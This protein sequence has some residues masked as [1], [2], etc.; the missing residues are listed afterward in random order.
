MAIGCPESNAN[1]A[2][3]ICQYDFKYVYRKMHIDFCGESPSYDEI[4]SFMTLTD[5]QKVEQLDVELDKCL[6]S[7][8]WMGK[9]GQVWQLAHRK[10]RPVGSLKYGEDAYTPYQFSDYYDDYSLFVY[11]QIDNHDARDILLATYF[12]ERSSDPTTYK[13][14]EKGALIGL[15]L[16]QEEYRAGM[17]TTQ[18]R[19]LY[20]VMFTPLPRTAA[21]Q[22]Y[23][24]FL[25]LDIA[26][27]E[28]LH[29]AEETP[30]DY[31]LRGVGKRECATCHST[32]DPLTYPFKNYNGIHSPRYQYDPMR[33]ETHFSNV[34][35]LTNTPE[36]GY[37]FGQPVAN[38]QEWASVAAN[39]RQF[40][41]ATVMDYWKL[42][43]GTKAAY[44]DNEFES[45]W[46][47]LMEKHE[48]SVE[49]ML[50]DLIKTE[51]YGA[52]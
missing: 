23:R 34:A 5:V 16:M 44:Y 41:S 40:A 25:G 27:L 37:I 33:M 11:T 3:K 1:S 2:Y 45:L 21:A 17:L 48:Y 24:A 14:T 52:P 6:D 26:K 30:A 29:P 43:V 32:L 7:E 51:A 4:L 12:V 35:N 47:N 31:D 13:A 28:G 36:N 50:H 20:D 15:Q 38:L 8:F 18:W 19:M 42:L 10:I 39:S 46:R 22:A 49:K 9:N